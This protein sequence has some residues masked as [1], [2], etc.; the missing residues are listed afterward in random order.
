MIALLSRDYA[1]RSICINYPP[2]PRNRVA[3]SSGSATFG[4]RATGKGCNKRT[5]Q[6]LSLSLSSAVTNRNRGIILDKIRFDRAIVLNVGLNQTE[7][8]EWNV[9]GERRNNVSVLFFLLL[10]FSRWEGKKKEMQ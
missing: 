1:R 8:F 10:D 2:L 5:G 9:K 6:R 3:L 4:G 7:E